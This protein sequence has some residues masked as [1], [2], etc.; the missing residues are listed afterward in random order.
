[1]ISTAA[2]FKKPAGQ[3]L[4]TVP[5]PKRVKAAITKTIGTKNEE[6]RSASR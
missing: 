5:Q 2:A 3:L 1:M 4:P 6:I